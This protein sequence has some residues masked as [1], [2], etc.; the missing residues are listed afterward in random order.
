MHFQYRQCLLIS[1][2]SSPGSILAHVRIILVEMLE[3]CFKLFKLG[4]RYISMRR[5]NHLS[6]QPFPDHSRYTHLIF[7]EGY[8]L[9]DI[10][11]CQS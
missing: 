1:C 10:T 5:R 11:F 2:L 4:R 6:C 3:C 9:A 7:D 8:L